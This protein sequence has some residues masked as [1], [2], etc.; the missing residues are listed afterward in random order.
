MEL[1]QAGRTALVTLI[2]Y[3][4]PLFIVLAM[5][6]PAALRSRAIS[7]KDVEEGEA[8]LKKKSGGTHPR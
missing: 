3:L 4:S 1:S 2:V 6:T 8:L 5:Q 7:K